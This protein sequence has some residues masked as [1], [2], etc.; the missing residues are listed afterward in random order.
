MRSLAVE[1]LSI[2]GFRNLQSVDLELGPGFNVLAGENGQGK[3]NVLEA[4]YVLATS[5]SF[6]TSRLADL[7]DTGAP[8]ESAASVRAVVREG[9][10]RREQ[11]VGIRTGMRAARIDG[12]RPA[13]L[14]GYA[15]RTPLVAFHAGVLA[16]S[17]GSGSERRRLLDRVALYLWP[18]SIADAEAYG[19][20]MRARQRAL[21]VR[22][23]RGADLDGWEE[24]MVRHG[25]ALS[26]S[27]ARAAELLRG[28]AEGAFDRI[29]TPGL[30]LTA[31]YERR[32]PAE[33]SEFRDAL[34]R[35]RARDRARGSASVG[36]HRDDLA[37]ELGA[38]PVRGLAS[39][40][41]HRA[42]VL[43]LELAEMELVAAARDVWPILLLDDV[44]SELDGERTRAV[45]R[46]LGQAPGARWFE[47]AGGSDERPAGISGGLARGPVHGQVVLTTTRPQLID[48]SGA[49]GSD[50]RRDFIVQ[51]GTVERAG[52]GRGR[53][54]VRA[55]GAGEEPGPR[56]ASRST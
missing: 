4:I 33:A 45:F 1:T 31:R 46:A 9:E 3:T 43:A 52:A 8:P 40:G 17:A 41:Q 56:G 29:G 21:E 34:A 25:M 32:A 55:E 48:L 16:L 42:V 10:E 11:S 38:R 30:R 22:G 14:A 49:I 5:R 51:A 20:A 26:G 47:A 19:K 18:G 28:A 23:E 24:L 27:R 50:D 36:P 13:T 35:N 7:V 54:E 39:Q 2:R 53:R 12:K 6:R 44:S 15:V 37:L